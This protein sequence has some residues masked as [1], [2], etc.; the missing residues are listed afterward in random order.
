MRRAAL[1]RQDVGSPRDAV[2]DPLQDLHVIR[3]KGGRA[4]QDYRRIRIRPRIDGGGY[5]R[6]PRKGIRSRSEP[7]CKVHPAYEGFRDVLGV[8][9][10]RLQ[11]V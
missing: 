2:A 9:L 1:E 5:G 11:R 6:R 3:G 10:D 8:L 7:G 4:D